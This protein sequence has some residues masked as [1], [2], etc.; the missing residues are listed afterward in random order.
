[1]LEKTLIFYASVIPL[2]YVF[3]V[4]SA[5]TKGAAWKILGGYEEERP[6]GPDF[7]LFFLLSM[8]WPAFIGAFIKGR[9]KHYWGLRE[10]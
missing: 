4:V 9:L 5:Y 1:M 10:V 7:F 2:S 8:A 3:L 6:E